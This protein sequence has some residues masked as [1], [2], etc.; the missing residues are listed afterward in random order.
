ME[1]G[2]LW[3]CSYIKTKDGPVPA[4]FS[5]ILLQKKGENVKMSILDN[6]QIPAIEGEEPLYESKYGICIEGGIGLPVYIL[7]STKRIAAFI[8]V[9]LLNTKNWLIR[10]I[11]FSELWIRKEWEI[12][13]CC[14]SDELVYIE[15]C[16]YGLNNKLL[17]FQKADGTSFTLGLGNCRKFE[18]FYGVIE[19]ML[20]QNGKKLFKQTY[21]VWKV[22]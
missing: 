14:M 9:S 6:M 5:V 2:V 18:E 1:Y 11:P 8:D 7:V 17:R 10:R 21:S 3:K 19:Q 16:K 20:E 12:K 15:R 13:H 4:V 22:S